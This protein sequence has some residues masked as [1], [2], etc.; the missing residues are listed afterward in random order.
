MSLKQKR[1]S[2]GSKIDNMIKKE[3]ETYGFN[4]GIRS[5]VIKINKFVHNNY[6]RRDRSK[7]KSK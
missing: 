2:W 5:S 7:E 6:R 3:I 4:T 1:I